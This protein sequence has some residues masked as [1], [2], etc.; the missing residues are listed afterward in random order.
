MKIAHDVAAVSE[1]VSEVRQRLH[2]GVIFVSVARIR[3]KLDVCTVYEWFNQ[4]FGMFAREIWLYLVPYF[5][6]VQEYLFANFS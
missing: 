2:V 5:R 6:L 3:I 4:A 1:V